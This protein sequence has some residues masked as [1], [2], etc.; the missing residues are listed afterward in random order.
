MSAA[1]HLERLFA[2]CTRGVV[3]VRAVPSGNREWTTIGDWPRLGPFVTAAVRARESVLVG[4]AT[5]QDTTTGA[6]DNL[7]EMAMLCVDVD[8]PPA[9][10]RTRLDDFP[11]PWSLFIASG[12]GSHLYWKLKEPFDLTDEHEQTRAA[13]LMR[14]LTAY[15]GGDV[16]AANPA[17]SPRL[18]GTRNFKYGAPRPVALVDETDSALNACE[19]EDFLPAEVKRHNRLVLTEALPVGARND[20]LF[21]LIRSLRSKGLPLQVVA[22]TIR[23]LNARYSEEPLPDAELTALLNHALRYPNRPDF[24]P[25]APRKN[26]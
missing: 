23:T 5:R 9:E 20:M 1:R 13:S 3:E 4:L 22:D 25:A 7:A 19:L 26:R 8:A 2:D 12:N 16:R 17:L 11:F 21:L 18:A 24:Q 6:L 10:V 15:L 14:R